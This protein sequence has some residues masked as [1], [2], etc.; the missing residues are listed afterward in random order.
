ML[1]EYPL[2]MVGGGNS[3]YI[4]LPGYGGH[5]TPGYTGYYP[6]LGTPGSSRRARLG[7][8]QCTGNGL[9][10]LS[11]AVVKLTFRHAGVTVAC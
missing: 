3:W 5:T 4:C 7:S 10:A 11:R 1:G 2:G 8:R 9:T 6:T